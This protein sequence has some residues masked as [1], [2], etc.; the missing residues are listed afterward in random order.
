MH[1]YRRTAAA[2]NAKDA[3]PRKLRSLLMA[4]DG[5]TELGTYVRSLS[6]FGD[7]GA[8]LGQLEEA[9]LVELVMPPRAGQAAA[10]GTRTPAGPAA[11]AS[12]WAPATGRSSVANSAALE[13]DD[14]A[15]W[16]RFGEPLPPGAAPARRADPDIACHQLRKALLLMSDFVTAHLPAQSLEIVLAL[17]ALGSVEQVIGS[18]PGYEALVAP[19]GAPARQHLA[20][21]RRVLTTR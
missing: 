10:Q 6:S 7:V 14:L 16:A 11:P 1:I 17:E 4:V 20:E 12:A 9:G 21:L 15:S 18:L 19:L 3:L 5:K 8:L 2:L 13:V